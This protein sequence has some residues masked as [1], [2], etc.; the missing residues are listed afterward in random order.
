MKKTKNSA[1]YAISRAKS[2]CESHFVLNIFIR[3]IPIFKEKNQYL[4]FGIE[5]KKKKNYKYRK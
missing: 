5:K 4:L 1:Y 2:V 3:N